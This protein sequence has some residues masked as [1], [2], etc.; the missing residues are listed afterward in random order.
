MFPSDLSI[1]IR[2]EIEVKGAEL[3]TNLTVEV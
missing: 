3:D 1:R 2:G